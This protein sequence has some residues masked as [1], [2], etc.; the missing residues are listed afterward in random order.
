MIKGKSLT[1]AES[2]HIVYGNIFLFLALALSLSRS[3]KAKRKLLC[4]ALLF[5]HLPFEKVGILFVCFIFATS[6]LYFSDE[7]YFH[8]A[9]KVL[10]LCI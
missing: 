6:A 4:A 3:R 10:G 7:V 8:H 9:L 2:A 5:K 1:F